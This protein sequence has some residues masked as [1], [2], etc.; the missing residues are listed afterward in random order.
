[1][2]LT[3]KQVKSINW[4]GISS[5]TTIAEIDKFEMANMLYGIYENSIDTPI[6]AGQLKMG[7]AVHV[8]GYDGAVK[9]KT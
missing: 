8:F 4:G 9:I 6:D 7:L 2:K 5:P 3:I 1:M